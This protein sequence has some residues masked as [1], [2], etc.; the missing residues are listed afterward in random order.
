MSKLIVFNDSHQADGFEAAVNSVNECLEKQKHEIQVKIQFIEDY[1][2][3]DGEY[4]Y[5]LTIVPDDL[6]E[7]VRTGPRREVAKK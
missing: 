6:P 3:D 4:A 5:H 1:V 7:T 2:S